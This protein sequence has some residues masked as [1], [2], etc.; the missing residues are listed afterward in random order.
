LYRLISHQA[1]PTKTMNTALFNDSRAT[2]LMSRVREDVS[3]LRHDIHHLI[4]HTTRQTLPNGARKL[5]DQAK[6]QL[7]AGGANATSQIRDLGGR[8]PTGLIGGAI[9]VG[10]LAVGAYALTH[11]NGHSAKMAS[12]GGTELETDIVKS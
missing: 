10:L 9:V 7:A 3:N 1:L 6:Q 4:S 11:H 2:G 5:A 12:A 8:H